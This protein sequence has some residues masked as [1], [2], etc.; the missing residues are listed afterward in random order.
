MKNGIR[1]SN[2]VAK[3]LRKHGKTLGDW[4]KPIKSRR[5]FSRQRANSF[6]VGVLFDQQVNAD[7]AWDA[8]EWIT[9][10][11]G[12]EESPFWTTVQAIDE[13]RLVG[14]MRYGWAGYAFHRHPRRMA[15]YL[16][17]CAEVINT[18][19]DGDP[20]K[21]WNNTNSLNKVRDRLEE[22]PGIGAALSRMAVLILVRRYGLFAGRPAL[23]QL[24]VKPD[25]LLKRVFRRTGL[26]SNNPQ[27]DD[28][29]TAA[30]RLAPEFPAVLDA[31]AWHIGRNF[32][33]PRGPN[34]GC[35]PLNECCPKVG[36]P[37]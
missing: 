32:C 8:A 10:S 17:G 13:E 7:L 37:Q 1:M 27:F 35:C 24:D 3:A 11:M 28:Y 16:K 12:N 26:V 19:Y 4:V 31:P 34:C 33:H 23:R 20:R 36:V 25:V 9:E 22:L 21:I 15:N 2:L 30:R 6:V 5:H 14:F 29:L 18:K